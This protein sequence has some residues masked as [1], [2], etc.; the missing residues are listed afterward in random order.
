MDKQ[1]VYLIHILFVGPLLLY[2]YHIGVQLSLKSK[3]EQY[4]STFNFVGIIGVVVI[5]YHIYS[6]LIFK[7][8]I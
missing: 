4:I 1:L 8:Y 7:N 6:L 5:I 2:L 3:D